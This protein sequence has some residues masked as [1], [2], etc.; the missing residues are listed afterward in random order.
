VRTISLCM[1]VKNEEAVL[2]RC[3]QSV[4]H[5]ADEMII[6]DTGSTDGTKKI[7]EEFGAKVYDF[8]WCNDFAKARNYAFSLATKT[9]ILWLDADD[10]IEEADGAQLAELKKTL[11]DDIDAVSMPYTLALNEVGDVAHQI[12]HNR[13]VKREKDFQWKGF[14]HEYLVVSG[15]IFHSDITFTHKNKTTHTDRNLSI[16]RERLGKGAILSPRDRYYFANELFHSQQCEEAAEQFQVFLDSGKGWVEDNINA[17]A[18]LAIC[19]GHMNHPELQLQCLL[20]TLEYSKPTPKF[21]CMLGDL[22]QARGKEKES[23]YWYLT[24]ILIGKPESEYAVLEPAYWTWYPHLQLCVTY[25]REGNMGK[26][27]LHHDITKQYYPTHPSIMYND[28][29]FGRDGE[30]S[31]LDYMDKES[32]VNQEVSVEEAE[33]NDHDMIRK[34]VNEVD[35]EDEQVSIEEELISDEPNRH[36]IKILVGSPIKQSPIILAH[37]LDSIIELQ[38]DRSLDVHYFF[39]DDNDHEESKE[40]LYQFAKNKNVHIIE[41]EETYQYDKDSF[42]HRWKNANVRNVSNMKNDILDYA[43]HNG[44][45]YAFLIDSDLLLHPNTLQQLLDADKDIISNIFWTKWVPDSIEMP[46]VWLQDEY[47]MFR[48]E[49]DQPLSENEMKM[50]MLEFIMKMRDPGVYEVGGLGACTLIS[51]RAIEAG[52]NFDKLYNVS[53]AGEDRHFCIRAAAL[54]FQLY[55]E[56]TYPAYHIYRE[57]DV[58]GIQKWKSSDLTPIV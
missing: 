53:Y 36:R 43:E 13:L 42:T 30:Q 3:L 21:C 48:K 9:Y 22:L 44:F 7:A 45:D 29:F 35:T 19:H 41:T 33:L 57:K 39:Y 32:R 1:I 26:A 5:V 23:V 2:G 58:K 8:E 34:L 37:F 14:V 54:G 18:K 40:L 4:R 50:K 38:K 47:Q 20:R 16:Y 51:R 31:V 10:V 56:T 52:V 55:V 27:Q 11:T 46:Q 49:T 17:C 6:V 12:R 28:Q 25:Y 24:A 15:T